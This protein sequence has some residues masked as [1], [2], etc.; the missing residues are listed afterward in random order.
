VPVIVKAITNGSDEEMHIWE[1][2]DSAADTPVK[3]NAAL[4]K[5]KAE[6]RADG[7]LFVTPLQFE[8]E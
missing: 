1:L 4:R 3:R 6:L 7:W 2:V 8:D 5:L